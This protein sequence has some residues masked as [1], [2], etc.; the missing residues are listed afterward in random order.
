MWIAEIRSDTEISI[1]GTLLVQISGTLLIAND[2][3]V[4]IHLPKALSPDPEDYYYEIHLGFFI[5]VF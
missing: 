1:S 2:T 4:T 3:L 5:V